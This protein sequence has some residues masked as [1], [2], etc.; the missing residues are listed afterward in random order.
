VSVVNPQGSPY[1]IKPKDNLGF[2]SKKVYSTS[3]LWD[4]LYYNNRT[5]IKNPNVLYSGFVIFYPSKEE[6]PQ[7]Q[8]AMA[9]EK[10]NAIAK[11]R[12]PASVKKK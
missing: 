6:I 10:F 4:E 11:T 8:L 1:L 3:R 5:I 12:L 7:V 9:N 2:I